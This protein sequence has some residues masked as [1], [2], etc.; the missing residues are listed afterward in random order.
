MLH[1][2]SLEAMAASKPSKVLKKPA[3]SRQQTILKKSTFL[4]VLKKPAASKKQSRQQKIVKKAAALKKKLAASSPSAG[5]RSLWAREL[6][7]L[8]A[9]KDHVV[10]RTLFTAASRGGARWVCLKGG[11]ANFRVAPHDHGGMAGLLLRRWSMKCPPLPDPPTVNLLSQIHAGEVWGSRARRGVKKAAGKLRSI[12]KK[13]DACTSGDFHY[14]MHNEILLDL[15][16]HYCPIMAAN[17]QSVDI[18]DSSVLEVID[19]DDPEDEWIE[20]AAWNRCKL[21]KD[22]D[23]HNGRQDMDADVDNDMF[24]MGS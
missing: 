19:E 13:W 4:K 3:S 11:R 2:T 20:Y 23:Y 21:D 7:L 12:L 8:R 10:R 22:S 1:H 18:L 15:V 14:I 17:E 5:D 24:G 9:G 16:K 6:A